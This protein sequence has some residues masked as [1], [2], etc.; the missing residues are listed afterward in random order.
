MNKKIVTVSIIGL[1]GRGGEA[2][3]RYMSLLK[4]KF[5]ITHIC[6]I[7]RTR[8]DKYGEIFEVPAE[9]RFDDEDSFFEKK[10]SDLLFIATQDR[11]HVRMAKKAL[12][13]G[14]DIVLEKPISDSVEELQ[15]LTKLAH[16]KNRK[17]I[18]C[19][20]L[21]YTVFMKKL[22]ELLN[23]GEIGRLV[24]IDQ[25]ENVVYWHEAH[26]YVRGNWRNTD[27][28]VPMIMAKCCHDLDLI[29]DFAGSRCK[30]V[31]SMGSLFYFKPENKPEG[32]A[33]RCLSC[34]YVNTCVYSAKRIYVE[35]WKNVGGPENEGP[36][37]LITDVC[38]LTEDALMQAIKEGPYGRCVF[39]CDNNVVDNQ[40]VIMQFENG[41]T[42]TLKME[43]FVKQGGRDIRFFG[44]EGELNLCEAEGT[45]TLKKYF[46]NDTVWRLTD[47]TDDLEGHGGGDHRI[48][49]YIYGVM[50][51]EIESLTTSIDNSVESH[52]MALAAEESRIN[53]GQLVELTKFR[54]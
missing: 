46:G 48:I 4:D 42:A 45:I 10:W 12:E 32:A 30:S 41:V 16:E 21:R 37:N 31:S 27:V 53:G 15:E 54:K 35:M 51:G 20:V 19:H 39:N 14:Y 44:T 50:T 47:L 36:F 7:N 2:Y 38:P 24:S 1:G 33:D 9:N 6:D 40:T 22:K 5:R 13:L 17:V 26:S 11:M 43:A 8:L 49:E 29:Q 3:G 18:V 52:Y 28:A 23:A 34:K 25:T